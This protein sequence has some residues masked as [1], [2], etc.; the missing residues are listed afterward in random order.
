M[1]DA[2]R[3]LL[4]VDGQGGGC[5]RA[6]IERLCELALPLHITAVGT[7]ARA[8][9]AMLKAGADAGATGE[10]AVRVCAARAD[11]IA[12]PLGI[13]LADAMLGE[14]TA[15]MAV[16]IGSAGAHRVLVPVNRCGT[17]VAGAEDRAMAQS[18]EDAAQLIGRLCG[19]A[20]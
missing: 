3:E 20:D 5:G 11:I 19:E 18:V 17:L 8:T 9:A 6:L 1:T 4:V 14:V 2:R 7:N 10:N 12:G 13:V 15:T 16:A